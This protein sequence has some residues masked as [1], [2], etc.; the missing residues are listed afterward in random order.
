MACTSTAA[1]VS[2]PVEGR[3]QTARQRRR[4][5]SPQPLLDEEL[6]LEACEA[7][8]IKP[9]SAYVMWRHLLQLGVESVAEIPELPKSLRRLVQERFTVTTSRV[10]SVSHSKDG[11]T[12][13]LLVELQDGRVVES[14]IMRYG[15]VQLDSFPSDL[16][17]TTED[18]KVVFRSKPRATLC[19]SSQVGCQMG[20]TF[21]ATGTMGLMSN[22]TSGEILEQ[23]YHANKITKIRGVVFMG[24]GEPLDNY[25]AVVMAIRG[26]TD[27]RRFSLSPNRVSVST[28]G[29]AP[30]LRQLAHDCPGVSLALSL[31]APNQELRSEIVPSSKAWHID[32]IMEAMDHYVQT[33]NMFSSR[34]CVVV[35]EYVLIANVNDHESTA[36]QLGKLLQERSVMLNVIPYNP[37]AVPFDYKAPSR[38]AA[39]AFC[40]IVR[41]YGVKT[42]LRQELGQDIGGACGQLVVSAEKQ[43]QG[44]GPQAAPPSAFEVDLTEP[45]PPADVEDLVPTRVRRRTASSSG[46]GSPAQQPRQRKTRRASG[47]QAEEDGMVTA[48]N[49]NMQGM[50]TLLL[51][52]LGGAFTLV[53][54]LTMR[55]YLRIF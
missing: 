38:E 3:P 36:H 39:D 14:V 9:R 53:L 46:R 28:V 50:N 15:C 10:K 44:K 41:T 5:L 47:S 1:M 40:Q 12:S 26:M 16:Q 51:W 54:Y 13:K 27:V 32:R 18:G 25:A 42:T 48:T 31:H 33:W 52:A 20:C 24:M 29:V 6:V 23:L 21:C 34:R 43:L 2:P 22:L 30:R 8:G 17:R 11:S 45:S 7:E 19:V 49:S 37:T 35:I 55:L 4:V